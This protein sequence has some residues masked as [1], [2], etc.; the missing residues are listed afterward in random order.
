MPPKFDKNQCQ[1]YNMPSWTITS[2]NRK[3][4]TMYA[5]RQLLPVTNKTRNEANKFLSNAQGWD[6]ETALACS[7][8]PDIYFCS[9]CK[10]LMLTPIML[11]PPF[12][13]LF[14]PI[15]LTIC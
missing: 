2:V 15:S 9:V 3:R 10:Q 11:V 6:I 12:I 7:K 4:V 13:Y 5:A 1:L 14:V 8:V